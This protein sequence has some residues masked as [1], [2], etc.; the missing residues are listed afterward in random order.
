MKKLLLT[1]SVVA[2]LGALASCSK[3][4]DGPS[5]VFTAQVDGD[6][7]VA[8]EIDGVFW[9]D[10]DEV[11]VDGYTDDDNGFSIYFSIDEVEE[12]ETYDLTDFEIYMV[13]YDEDEASFIPVNGEISVTKLTESRFEATFEFDGENYGSGDEIEVTDGVVKADLEEVD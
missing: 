3:D 11:Y 8:D 6:D 13:Y 7:F 5:N 1:F 2:A 12:G 4:D 9:S 10:D